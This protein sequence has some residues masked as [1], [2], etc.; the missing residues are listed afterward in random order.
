MKSKIV[1]AFITIG[2]FVTVYPIAFLLTGSFMNT[3]E[4]RGN[5]YPIIMSASDDYASWSLLPMMPSVCSYIKVLL[6]EP[7]F[8]TVFWNSVKIAAGVLIGQAVFGIPAAWGFARYEFRF[9]KFLFLIYI[10]MMMMPFQVI[11]LSQYLVLKNLALLDSL[12]AIIIPGA[13]STFPVFVIYNF[14]CRIPES[15]IEAARLDGAGEFNIFMKIGLPLGKSGIVASMILQMLEYWNIVEQPMIFL[16]KKQ[17]W[18]LTLYLPEI[19]ME[20]AGQA[21]AASVIS[22]IPAMLVFILCKDDLEKGIVAS[23]VKE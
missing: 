18:P 11:M 5:L 14:F 23:A 20:N 6:E 12:W 8:F 10:V 22:L 17:L 2:A 4:I 1:L 3:W 9:K 13:F 19:S 7:Q 21:F 16:E 15:L